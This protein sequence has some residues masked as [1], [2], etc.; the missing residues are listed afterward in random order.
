MHACSPRTTR[1]SARRIV[2][3]S[4]RPHPRPACRDMMWS[5]D[6]AFWNERWVCHGCLW[7]LAQCLG[8]GSRIRESSE[9][10]GVVAEGPC[11]IHRSCVRRCP[12]VHVVLGLAWLLITGSRIDL[13]I[14]VLKHTRVATCGALRMA[15]E[16]QC[17]CATSVV[18]PYRHLLYLMSCSRGDIGSRSSVKP[19]AAPKGGCRSKV[20]RNRGVEGR[21]WPVLRRAASYFDAEAVPGVSPDRSGARP[22]RASLPWPGVLCSR[23]VLLPYRPLSCLCGGSE[24]AG[25]VKVLGLLRKLRLV[26]CVSVSVYVV[27]IASITSS[28]PPLPTHTQGLL[29]ACGGLPVHR[30]PLARRPARS[31]LRRA[32]LEDGVQKDVGGA[33]D[34]PRARHPSATRISRARASVRGAPPE[35][36]GPKMSACVQGAGRQRA[37]WRAE[38]GGGCSEVVGSGRGVGAGHQA[39]PGLLWMHHSPQL[40]G[41]VLVCRRHG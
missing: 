27:D 10:Q 11:G 39:Q 15:S 14:G 19:T 41:V 29:G 36:R 8:C 40:Q 6:V 23:G 18:C 25:C 33:P 22:L 12:P 2:L 35:R 3:S 38:V 34:R 28:P 32:V 30:A 7:C 20:H 31:A 37:R 26:L 21:S 13:L 16:R 1:C 5:I 9:A 24:L 17:A 4:R